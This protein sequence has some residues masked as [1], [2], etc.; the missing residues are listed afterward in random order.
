MIADKTPVVVFAFNRSEPLKMV[1]D[2][3]SCAEGVLERDLI[4]YIDGPR[5][6]SDAKKIESVFSVVEVFKKS[7]LPNI[8]VRKRERN[9]GCQRNIS[10]AIS[11]VLAAYGRIIVVEDDVLV[12]RYFLRYMDDALT[13]Y[14]NDT[15]IWGVNGHQCPYMRLPMDF[16]GDVY[17]S[18]RNLCTGWGTWKDRWNKVDFQIKD[19]PQFIA[20]KDN[21][22]KICSAGWDI[23]AM[24]DKHYKGKL[25]S[26]ALPCTYYMVKHDMY[27]VEPRYSLTKNVGFGLESVHCGNIE[28]VWGHQ[29]YYNYQPHLIKQVEPDSCVM[30]RFRYVYNDPRIL[31]RI[32]RKLLRIYKFW[33]PMHN[34]PIDLNKHTDG[35]K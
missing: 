2:R 10:S 32:I 5:N 11:E 15:R 17:L 30:R 9:L 12:S 33:T 21:A 3:L 22:Q 7:T 14:E 29:K 27:V 18:P 8:E 4:V 20:D 23:K 35:R 13:L 34:E 24:L 28:S 31:P 16:K 26:W 19:W 25:N 1:L 6:E